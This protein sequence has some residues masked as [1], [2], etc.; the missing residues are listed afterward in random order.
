M[1]KTQEYDFFITYL[2]D[3]VKLFLDLCTDSCRFHIPPI[4][5]F[6]RPYLHILS[7]I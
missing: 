6:S 1:R 3:R 2:I 7:M 5:D 4:I